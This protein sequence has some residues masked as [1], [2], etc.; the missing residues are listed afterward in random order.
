MKILK[1]KRWESHPWSENNLVKNIDVNFLKKIANQESTD[2]TDLLNGEIVHQS[3]VWENIKA[4]GMFEPLLIV[5]GFDNKRIRLESGNHRI[6]VAIEDGYTH[7]PTAILVLKGNR[8][9]DGNGLHDY[10]ANNIVNWRNLVRCPYPYQ[11]SPEKVL[12]SKLYIQEDI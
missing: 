11:I 7:L 9:Y 2:Y 4:E 6:K 8:I 5:I 12:S 1:N 10:D 3:I